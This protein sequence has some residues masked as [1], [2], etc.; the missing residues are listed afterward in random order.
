MKMGGS[1]FRQLYLVGKREMGHL[2]SRPLYVF[3]MILAPI[4]IYIFFTTLMG[5]GLPTD[6]PVGVVDL[7]NT[8]STRKMIRTLDSFEQTAVVAQY[9]DVAQ[10]RKAMQQGKIYAFLYIPKNT[11]AKILSSRRPKISFYTNNSLLIAGSLLYRDLRTMTVLAGGYVQLETMKARGYTEAQGTTWA[12]PIVIDMKPLNNPWL[13]YSVYLNNTIVPG[14]LM[15]F[16]FMITV[17]TIGDE[18]KNDTVAEWMRLANGNVVT[19]LTG[20][21]LP[22]T[23]IFFLTTALYDAY[24]FGFLHYPC[25]GG[26]FPMLLAAL[27]MVVA[28]QAFGIFLIGMIPN[29]RL[30]L[31][32]C[33]LWGVVS[34][35]IS[36]FSYPVMAMHPTLQ[37]LS[38]L[39]PLRHYY[40]IYVNSALDGYPIIYAWPSLLAL[41]L[42][43]LL[44]F[45]VV[46][47][48]YTAVSYFKY[49]P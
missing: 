3:S 14:V 32:G 36:G 41:M 25:N 40:L 24:F 17:Y 19:A 12:Q 4:F 34:F 28:S 11:T 38:Y 13:N 20:K 16:I 15:I 43:C 22:Q 35:S 27:L 47:R 26:P 2:V 39:F 23:I 7:D 9:T 29:L 42:F 6:M 18:W 37:A 10:A 48:L 49:Q 45:F 31:C 30:A 44:P 21:L 8:I 46:K 1:Y 5:E 33:S